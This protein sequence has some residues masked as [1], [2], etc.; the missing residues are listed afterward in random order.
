[1]NPYDDGIG[2]DLRTRSTGSTPQL[3]GSVARSSGSPTTASGSS[4]LLLRALPDRQRRA[5][6]RPLLHGYRACKADNNPPASFHAAVPETNRSGQT[7]HLGGGDH[8]EVHQQYATAVLRDQ[9]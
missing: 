5:S 9:A 3:L 4:R 8:R 6:L 7:F 1:M 2:L